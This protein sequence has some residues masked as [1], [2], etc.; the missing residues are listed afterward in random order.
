MIEILITRPDVYET[1]GDGR[2]DEG[3]IPLVGAMAPDAEVSPSWYVRDRLR[4]YSGRYVVVM[5]D[6]R[7]HWSLVGPVFLTRRKTLA[8]RNE[9]HM[10]AWKAAYMYDDYTIVYHRAWDYG[11][12]TPVRGEHRRSR[13]EVRLNVTTTF[14]LRCA[15][16]TPNGMHVCPGCALPVFYPNFIPNAEEKDFERC[17][18][19]PEWVRTM[20][21]FKPKRIPTE[22]VGVIKRNLISYSMASDLRMTVQSGIRLP[23]YLGEDKGGVDA[24]WDE[25]A[26]VLFQFSYV[27]GISASDAFVEKWV[28]KHLILTKQV[29]KFE[30][31]TEYFR[32]NPRHAAQW[33]RRMTTS[34]RKFARHDTYLSFYIPMAYVIGSAAGHLTP[35]YPT[36]RKDV[37]I[38]ESHA[39]ISQLRQYMVSE[40]G[41]DEKRRLKEAIAKVQKAINAG[42]SEPPAPFRDP[43]VYVSD[44]RVRTV[45]DGSQPEPLNVD[46][47]GLQSVHHAAP[48]PGPKQE[49]VIKGGKGKGKKGEKGGKGGS[50]SGPPPKS[51]EVPDEGSGKGGSPSVPKGKAKDDAGPAPMEVDAA[52]AQPKKTW[53]AIAVEGA[54]P[55]AKAKMT[56]VPKAEPK[57][58]VAS[59]PAAKGAPAPKAEAKET[60][61]AEPRSRRRRQAETMLLAVVGVRLK[62]RRERGSLWDPDETAKE[63]TK[64]EASTRPDDVDSRPGAAAREASG[65]DL[66]SALGRSSAKDAVAPL[67]ASKAMAK[68]PE[69]GEIRL[70]SAERAA[71]SP[72]VDAFL[73]I[74][75]NRVLNKQVRDFI[76]NGEDASALEALNQIVTNSRSGR[77]R[78]ELDVSRTPS[79]RSVRT[80]DS[81]ESRRRRYRPRREDDRDRRRDDARDRRDDESLDRER[82]RRRDDR[83]RSERDRDRDRARGGRDRRRRDDSR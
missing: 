65:D 48:G 40:T 52:A 27:S 46:I 19:V 32:A 83:R 1:I 13:E 81:R 61:Q 60:K 30:S 24:A 8:V 14:C 63:S 72:V 31:V 73:S 50:P 78:R 33:G 3:L 44:E 57:G 2:Q 5:V 70:Q 28:A 7:V 82:D 54:R 18:I 9:I 10:G 49:P 77:R 58:K 71:A 15:E 21:Q 39:L 37:D 6:L 80:V 34:V 43:F 12:F 47:E 29:D 56:P 35:L 36:H 11:D 55:S 67:T 20:G 64:R 22:V 25:L 74:S 69:G 17:R 45:I 38:L 79:W 41:Y 23:P 16:M 42:Q 75:T 53:V 66:H 68:K 76:R 62:G 26:K 51:G 59:V 4:N